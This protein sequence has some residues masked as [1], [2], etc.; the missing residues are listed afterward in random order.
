[1]RSDSSAKASRTSSGKRS[2][3][4]SL[5]FSSST[6]ST[7]A[8]AEIARAYAAKDDRIVLMHNELN[9]GAARTRNRAL[10]AARGKFITFMDADD[11]CSP[12]RF[13]I[14]QTKNTEY[15]Y[16]WE[17]RT[18]I[19]NLEY[20]NKIYSRYFSGAEL[21]S[22]SSIDIEELNKKLDSVLIEDINTEEIILYHTHTTEA[23]SS[24]EYIE[25]ETSKTV[26]E[27]FNVISVGEKLKEQ[28][29]KKGFKVNHIKKYNDING[30][31]R[32]IKIH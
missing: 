10:D 4:W 28:L 6:T 23:Y 31:K 7:D 17:Y 22:N 1:M 20:S 14:N 19:E 26:D 15:E 18:L 21:I 27:N 8:S 12:E 5:N 29:I 3:T 25:I 13:A 11:L 32:H 24:N 30:V 2:A 9:S 16:F